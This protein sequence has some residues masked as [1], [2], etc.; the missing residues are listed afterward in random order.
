MAGKS[1]SHPLAKWVEIANLLPP[2]YLPQ[3]WVPQPD[4]QYKTLLNEL[5]RDF[6]KL[7]ASRFGGQKIVAMRIE[8]RKLGQLAP[9]G[10][11]Y[12]V[13]AIRL[14]LGAII[15]AHEKIK[16]GQ[17]INHPGS[18]IG[19]FSL[20][21]PSVT[22]YAFISPGSSIIVQEDLYGGFLADLN[23]CDLS[24]LKRCPVCSRPFLFRRKDQKACSPRCSNI[25]RV[26]RSR[27]SAPTYATNRKFRKRTGLQA[28]RGRPR[29]NAL[30]LYKALKVSRGENDDE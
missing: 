15:D 16:A 3:E 30:A 9:L 26:R 21:S 1:K 18:D 27:K 19:E 12:H 25:E 28:V 29:L 14:A 5:C 11:Y 17:P 13:I 4:S 6:Q 24:P 8:E 22:H 7:Q 23:G 20:G 10:L 2:E